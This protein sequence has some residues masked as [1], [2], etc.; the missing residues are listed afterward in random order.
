MMDLNFTPKSSTVKDIDNPPPPSSSSSSTQQRSEHPGQD[1]DVTAGNKKFS[2]EDE[3]AQLFTV[4]KRKTPPT[5]TKAT[6][7]SV[8]VS[9]QPE[10][11]LEPHDTASGD[12]HDTASDDGDDNQE[13]IDIN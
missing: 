13:I 1:D 10:V 11:T 7:G 12:P 9:V 2:E 5:Q 6:T 8:D 4:T 3:R